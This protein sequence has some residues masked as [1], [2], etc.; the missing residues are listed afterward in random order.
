MGLTS[1]LSLSTIIYSSSI[2]YPSNNFSLDFG[3]A[4]GFL[5]SFDSG[6]KTIDDFLI[7]PLLGD[8]V[9]NSIVNVGIVVD[10]NQVE[11][12]VDLLDIDSV[13]AITDELGGLD[14]HFQ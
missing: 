11:L 6:Y 5:Y 7:E 10:L 1:K 12:S 14:G 4:S 2:P 9:L 13:E 8:G 3:I